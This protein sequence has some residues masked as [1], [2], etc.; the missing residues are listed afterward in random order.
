[1]TEIMDPPVMQ[2]GNLAKVCMAEINRKY[3]IIV[4]TFVI[5]FRTNKTNM[6]ENHIICIIIK[7]TTNYAEIHASS[8]LKSQ[9]RRY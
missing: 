4:D 3:K 8:E 9:S 5:L 1:M 2:H 6:F 7:L